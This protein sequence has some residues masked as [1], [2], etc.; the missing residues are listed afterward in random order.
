MWGFTVLPVRVLDQGFAI[1]VYRMCIMCML[2]EAQRVVQRQ[3][4]RF[5]SLQLQNV[6]VRLELLFVLYA[7]PII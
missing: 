7:T 6:A 1:S 2:I 5:G 3:A 4:R